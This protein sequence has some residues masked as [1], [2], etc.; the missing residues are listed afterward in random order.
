MIIEI[1]EVDVEN[2]GVRCPQ[3]SCF[4]TS[5]SLLKQFKNTCTA[6]YAGICIIDGV[7]TKFYYS[8]FGDHGDIFS[9]D[10]S[11]RDIIRTL[12]P[13]HLLKKQKGLL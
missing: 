6:A 8:P 5:K 12:A 1:I 3:A 10:D 7:A 2:L 13:L 4:N 9:N 11:V